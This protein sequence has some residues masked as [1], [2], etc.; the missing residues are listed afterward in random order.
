MVVL[1]GNPAL[2]TTTRPRQQCGR[3]K[4]LL[5]WSCRKRRLCTISWKRTWRTTLGLRRMRLYS[6]SYSMLMVLLLD[7]NLIA[8]YIFHSYLKGSILFWNIDPGCPRYNS[9]YSNVCML[10]F[11]FYVLPTLSGNNP[12]GK[13]ARLRG[14]CWV[15]VATGREQF[16][17]SS[18]RSVS[19]PEL[20]G[21]T[22]C[23]SLCEICQFTT[24]DLSWLMFLISCQL[25]QHNM[26]LN[27][28]I[29]CST[30]GWYQVRLLFRH[31]NRHHN[32]PPL[33]T[34]GW[35]N[36]LSS[37]SGSLSCESWRLPQIGVRR[38]SQGAWRRGA[39][40]SQKRQGWRCRSWPFS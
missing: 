27:V 35:Y 38:L 3:V 11:I 39:S 36:Q 34:R 9:C 33:Y 26:L 12:S 16:G 40:S 37:C 19:L 2:G 10:S 29:S 18:C 1:P 25:I 8:T 13:L 5:T 22:G 23:W 31:K 17:S 32:E 24:R 4:V 7:F 15:R 28:M 21:E 30:H 6:S 20:V 14:R